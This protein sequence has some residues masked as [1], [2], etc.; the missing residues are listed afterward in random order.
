[1]ANLTI[2]GVPNTLL[3]ALRKRAELH[4]RSLNSE[5]LHLLESAVGATEIDPN[6]VIARIRQLQERTAPPPLTDVILEHAIEEGRP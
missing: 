1:M 3:D 5:V 6:V 4:R 2:M